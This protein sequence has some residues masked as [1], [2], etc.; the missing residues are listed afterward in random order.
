MKPYDVIND[1]RWT[2]SPVR[3]L[4]EVP[5]IKLVEY[6]VDE[7]TITTQIKYY[8]VGAVNAVSSEPG[9]LTPYEHLFPKNKMVGKYEFP[10]FSDINF[11]ISTP[12]WQSLDTVGELGKAIQSGVGLLF[13][14]KAAA[15]AGAIG[16]AVGG[17]A[18]GGL[19]M[20]Y[21]KVGIMDRPR[22]WQNHDFR[23]INVKFPLFNTYSPDDWKKNRSLCERLLRQNLYFKRD[24]IT[25]IPP[26]F[27]EVEIPGQHFSYASCATNLT[28]YNRGNMRTLVNDSGKEVVVPDAYEINLTLTDMVM[29]S[30]NL[31][32]RVTSPEVTSS[33][34]KVNVNN[35][36]STVQSF[37]GQT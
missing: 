15:A 16:G 33:Q 22:L 8:S 7:S 2:L 17:L 25:G 4:E 31:F 27:Y 26:V 29:P 19:A 1:Y 36:N 10:Y 35:I 34:S 23:S 13:G 11:E 28:I 3:S 20:T 21:P 9:G 18:M 14:E 12:V 5:K 24:F 37:I 30:K 6:E 32:D